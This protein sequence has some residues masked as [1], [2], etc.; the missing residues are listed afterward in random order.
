MR[1][2]KGP[3]KT[4]KKYKKRKK[5]KKKKIRPFV[6]CY[7]FSEP[8]IF[9]Q[10]LILFRRPINSNGRQKIYGGIELVSF[11]SLDGT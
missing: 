4:M 7:V 3:E 1:K 2:M 6:F 11:A 9:L 5:K 10:F 8:L